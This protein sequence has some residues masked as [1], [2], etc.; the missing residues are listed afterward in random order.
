MSVAGT[1]GSRHEAVYQ[2]CFDHIIHR[3]QMKQSAVAPPRD[4]HNL[5]RECASQLPPRGGMAACMLN[6]WSTQ[7]ARAAYPG[8]DLGD[9]HHG[10]GIS[11]GVLNRARTPAMMLVILIMVPA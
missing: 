1:C 11:K 4:V 9:L 10:A 8:D 3:T 5:E 6:T 2:A 7:G